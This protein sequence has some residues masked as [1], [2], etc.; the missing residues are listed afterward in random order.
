MSTFSVT[1]EYYCAGLFDAKLI[2]EY[3]V[4]VLTLTI[5]VVSAIRNP[6]I[7]DW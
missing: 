6:A 2:C 4:A 1:S 7:R 3:L 5:N